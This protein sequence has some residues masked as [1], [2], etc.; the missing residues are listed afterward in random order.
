MSND[1][2]AA[3]LKNH[4]RLLGLTFGLMVLLGQIGNVAATAN[5][6]HCAGP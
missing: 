2:L 1:K 4:P 6:G 3:Q 5:C